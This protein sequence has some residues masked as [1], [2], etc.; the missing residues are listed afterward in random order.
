MQYF[1]LRTK[2]LVSHFVATC[3]ITS[4]KNITENP[5]NSSYIPIRRRLS[6]LKPA[7]VAQGL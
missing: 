6:D 1:T 2:E 3:P 7:G 4:S 5:L